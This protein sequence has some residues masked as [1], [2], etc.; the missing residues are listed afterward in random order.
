MSR[1]LLAAALILSITACAADTPA[2]P[3][4]VAA[5]PL[6]P[7]AVTHCDATRAQS[8]VGQTASEDTVGKVVFDTGAH[9]SR[10][11]KPEQPVT[12]DHREDRVSIHVDAKN[13]ITEVACG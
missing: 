10:V 2:P 1:N 7:V 12:M 9:A 8:A 6:S 3:A 11:L 4:E 13:V 5:D